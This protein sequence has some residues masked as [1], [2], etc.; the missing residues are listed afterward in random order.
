MSFSV[1]WVARAEQIEARIWQCCFRD[2]QPGLFWFR[3]LERA[4]LEDQFTFLYGLVLSDGEPVGIVPAFIFDVPLELV[5]PPA[6]MR[7]LNVVAVGRL[8][9][10]RYQRTF[11]IGNSVGIFSAFVPIMQIAIGIYQ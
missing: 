8:R 6:L 10:L 2:G 5:A 11:F 3:A 1:K 7:V 9:R 4:R